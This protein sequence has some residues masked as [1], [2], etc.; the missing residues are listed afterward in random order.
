MHQ[1]H[2]GMKLPYQAI[3]FDLE[4]TIIDTE[5]LWDEVDAEFVSRRGF[6]YDP[7]VSKHLLMGGTVEGA[8]KHHQDLHGFGGD[9]AELAEE[10]R[11]IFAKLL[12]REVQFIPGFTTF[13]QAIAAT[14]K[15]A[16]AT[17]MTHRFLTPTEAK[18]HLSKFFGDHIYSIEEIGFIPKPN[19]D[20]FLH[21]AAKL[22]V[23]PTRCLVVEDAPNGVAAAKAAGMRV[24]ALTTSTT[25][26]RLSQADFVVDSYA[27]ILPRIS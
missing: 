2:I 17:S 11:Q 4:G 22:H 3:I 23:D 7:A 9:V 10:R 1:P 5:P 14:H 15:T 16:I 19:P 21:A 18:L 13:H 8:V 6:T 25:A 12:E 20:I 24:V 26:E 27:E